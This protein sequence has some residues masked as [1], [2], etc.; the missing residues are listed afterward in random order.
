MADRPPF[1]W[2]GAPEDFPG[3]RSRKFDPSHDDEYVPP[4]EEDRREETQFTPLPDRNNLLLSAWLERDFPPR[5]WL[6]G[7]VLCTTSRCL[8]IGETGVGKTLT[9]L[10]IAGAISSGAGV[11]GWEGKRHARV[12]YLDGELAKET[13]KERMELVADRYGEGCE[14]FGY[15]RDEL[16]SDHMPPIDTDIGQK[17][18]WHEIEKVQP[19]IIFFDA[20][21][22]L[23]SG[24]MSEE[25]SWKPIAPLCRQITSR[26]IAQVW[27]HHTGHDTSKGFGTKTREWEMESVIMLTKVSGDDSDEAVTAQFQME[28][29]KARNQNAKNFRQFE[30]KTITRTP[31]GFSFIKAELEAGKGRGNGNG[32]DG[33]KSQMQIMREAILETYELLANDVEPAPGFDE[34]PVRKV[35]VDAIRDKLK[36][37]GFLAT[38]DKGNIT[39]AARKALNSAKTEL[40]NKRFLVEDDGQI[41][42]IR[43]RFQ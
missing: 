4:G 33:F 13:F 7:E 24:T 26:G 39:G 2:N 5:D 9:A 11:F 32:N 27:L 3:M 1:T 20:I 29:K 19:D 16:P 40:I 12:M 28:F 37:R 42:R 18:L 22:C 35:A 23:T 17:W 8:L 30:T 14:I 6:L 31:E 21:M 41:W 34:K 36:S 25:E 38:D 15:N 43:D 10:E